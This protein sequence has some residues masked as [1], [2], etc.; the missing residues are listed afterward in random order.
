MLYKKFQLIVQVVGCVTIGLLA[1]WGLLALLGSA[2]P[3]W[4]AIGHA[5]PLMAPQN[6]P[7][8]LNYQGF[9]RNPDGSLTTGEYTITARIYDQATA[10]TTLYTTTVPNVTVR[11]GLFN[12]VLGDNPALDPGVFDDVPRYI[13]ISLNPDPEL[14]PRQRLHAVPWA[15]T[16]KTLVANAELE[17]AKVNGNV[18]IQTDSVGAI[19]LLVGREAGGTKLVLNDIDEAR[20]GFD[21][22]N[23][24]LSFRSDKCS[25]GPC[26]VTEP[27][28]WPA[29]VQIENDGDISWAGDLKSL[30]VHG[31]WFLQVQGIGWGPGI[32]DQTQ[33]ITLTA[34][35]NS[36]CFITGF[37]TKESNNIEAHSACAID[38]TPGDLNWR[39]TAV[40]QDVNR[41]H[42]DVMCLEW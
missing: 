37:L 5:A 22:F 14:I 33:T 15:Y 34:V 41:V 8:T 4:A 20:W 29:V 6:I 1:V 31:P 16:A 27:G 23:Y 2:S 28:L 13:G 36:I 3:T 42:C 12:I 30:Q 35:S 7:V 11:D 40:A 18:G 17:N 38:K 10:G 9:L 21:T 19:P 26:N 32:P 25:T 24:T 39:A